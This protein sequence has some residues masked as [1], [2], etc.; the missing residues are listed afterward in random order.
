MKGRFRILCDTGGLRID[1]YLSEKLSLTR[2]RVQGLIDG[3]HVRVL[4]GTPKPSLK[5]RKGM[6]IEGEL[7]EEEKADLLPEKIPLTILYEDEYLLAINKAKGMVVHPSFGHARG[8]LAN[9]VLSYLKAP[10]QFEGTERPGIVHR[11]DKD[12]TGVILVARDSRTQEKLSR[13]FHDR[14][15]DKVYRAVV[16]GEMKEQEGVVEGNMGRHPVERKKMALVQKGGRH[17]LSR[18]R[19]IKRLKKFTYLEV[20]P[21]TGRTHQI[22]VHL[23]HIG[24]PVVG[25]PLYGKR[26]RTAAQRPLLHAYRLTFDHPVSGKRLLVEAPVPEDMEQFIEEHAE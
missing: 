1:T 19:T 26:A 22:R 2:S 13:Q 4:N 11:L 21:E 7:V 14:G 3:G 16:E 12:T 9:A 8:T 10:D 25:D 6:E 17:S 5:V 23:A 15:V 20:H 24:H 18:Y